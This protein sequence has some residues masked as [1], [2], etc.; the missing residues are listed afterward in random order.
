MTQNQTFSLDPR[1]AQSTHDWGHVAP[2]LNLRLV[3]DSRWPWLMIVPQVDG[4]VELDDLPPDLLIQMMQYASHLA[5][6]LRAVTGASKTNIAS[7]G[8]MVNQFH[9]HIV[10]RKPGDP[11]WPAPVWGYGEAVPY[12]QNEARQLRNALMPSKDAK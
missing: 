4:L 8:N 11:A 1:L 7:I 2:L 5:E 9:L 3:N 12:T 10:A 6:A